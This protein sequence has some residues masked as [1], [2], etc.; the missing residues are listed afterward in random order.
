VFDSYVGWPQQ[1]KM[2]DYSTLISDATGADVAYAATFNG[3]QDV[4][5]L[6]LFPDCNGNARSD[7]TDI[8]LH[9]SLDC[10]LNQIPD[11]CEAAPVC[12]GAGNVASLTVS[13][14]AGDAI[15]LSWGASCSASDADYAVYE[16]SIGSFASQAPRTC[17]TGAM[18][19]LSFTPAVGNDYYLVVPVHAD[20][21]GSYGTDSTGA[22]RPQGIGACDPQTIRACGL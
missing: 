11:E 9:T 17:S 20:R 5:Y 15:T 7:V 3:E 14:G 2:G 22:E 16:G 4:Y 10:N 21:E 18:Q 1:N 8:A 12:I 19:S 6:R 13:K